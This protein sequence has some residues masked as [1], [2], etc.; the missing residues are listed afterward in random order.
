M[1]LLS[2]A[3]GYN[4]QLKPLTH[5]E[6]HDCRDEPAGHLAVDKLEVVDETIFVGAAINAAD[7][8]TCGRLVVQECQLR[9]LYDRQT[10]IET[11]WL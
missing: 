7:K 4:K 6:D 10:D 11:L 1:L 3:I 5:Q 9:A 2:L 8:V